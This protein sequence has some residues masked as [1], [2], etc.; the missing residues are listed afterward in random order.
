MIPKL[1]P[2]RQ[3]MPNNQPARLTRLRSWLRDLASQRGSSRAQR[4]VRQTGL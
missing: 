1:N 4:G 2:T 3:P